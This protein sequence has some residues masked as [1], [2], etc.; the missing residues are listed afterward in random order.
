M[1]LDADL[2]N[3][4][5]E[6]VN[7]AAEEAALPS[8]RL[9]CAPDAARRLQRAQLG[10]DVSEWRWAA[11]RREKAVYFTFSSLQRRLLSADLS[12]GQFLSAA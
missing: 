10:T 5:G 2:W 6:V 9:R 7:E 4:P 8:A 1:Q 11:R 3:F 12:S